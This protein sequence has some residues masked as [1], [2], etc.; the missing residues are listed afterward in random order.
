MQEQRLSFRAL[1]LAVVLVLFLLHLK[2]V[3][4]PSETTTANARR[5]RGVVD[6]PNVF[7]G[8]TAFILP[9]STSTDA[10]STADSNGQQA[11]ELHPKPPLFHMIFST[12]DETLTTLN[13]RSIESIFYFHPDARLLIHTRSNGGLSGLE[14]LQPLLDR[15]FDITLIRY[16]GPEVW[17]QSVLDTSNNGVDRKAADDF[18]ARLPELSQEKYWYSNE[19]NLLRMCLLYLVGGIYMDTDVILISPI[20][21]TNDRIDNA[22]GRND[23]K[24]H[25]AVMKFT[26]P[27]NLFLAATISNFLRNY[28]GT[29]WGVNGPKAFG[30]AAEEHPELVCADDNYDYFGNNDESLRGSIS[31]T[32]KDDQNDC[33]LKPLPNEAF[34]P[35]SWK[36]WDEICF[37]DQSHQLQKDEVNSLTARS[38][39]VHLNNRKTGQKLQIE[40]YQQGSLCDVVLSSFCTECLN[41]FRLLQLSYNL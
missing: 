37:S 16:R 33:W 36:K 26:Q 13:L 11:Q 7:D 19:T 2:I 29:K 17:L 5:V 15:D 39:A 35:V 6:A 27:G 24:F 31:N 4:T 34:A 3:W 38:F 9:P 14:K 28:D 30:R 8:R 10:K 12:G 23:R 22:M 25:C 18:I 20:L 1:F 32:A 21:A 41:I 40:E